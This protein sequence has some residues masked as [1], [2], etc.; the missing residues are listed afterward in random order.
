MGQMTMCRPSMYLYLTLF[1]CTYMYGLSSPSSAW[2][3]YCIYLDA[4]AHIHINSS[5]HRLL[6]RDSWWYLFNEFILFGCLNSCRTFHQTGILTSCFGRGFLDTY[7]SI[8]FA[9]D[10]RLSWSCNLY[11][12][13]KYD[14]DTNRALQ[15]W[16]GITVQKSHMYCTTLVSCIAIGRW[17]SSLLISACGWS[18]ITRRQAAAPMSTCAAVRGHDL[19]TRP[20][21]VMQNIDKMLHKSPLLLMVQKSCTSWGW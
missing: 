6:D 11:T 2:S 16:N 10:L 17:I 15:I 12:A 14:I 19:S 20:M 13:R 5:I 21:E 1:L 4:K 7:N 3:T 9:I 8:Y 18:N